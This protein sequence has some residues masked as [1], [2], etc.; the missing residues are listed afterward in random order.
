MPPPIENIISK[1]AYNKNIS[2]FTLKIKNAIDGNKISIN[3]NPNFDLFIK[4]GTTSRVVNAITIIEINNNI[5]IPI[6][7]FIIKL[8]FLFT[9]SSQF[10]SRI[11]DFIDS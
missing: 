8:S 6:L 10:I 5:E 9:A 4:K 7:F 3:T 1:I 2:D 11:D